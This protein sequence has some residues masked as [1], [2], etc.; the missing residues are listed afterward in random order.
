MRRFATDKVVRT[1]L[2]SIWPWTRGSGVEPCYGVTDRHLCH[3][4]EPV[5][6][7][8]ITPFRLTCLTP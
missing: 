2:L 6:T 8:R 1:H 7:L 5:F 3:P 4:V